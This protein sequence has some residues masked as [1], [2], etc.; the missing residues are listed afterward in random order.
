MSPAQFRTQC[1][2][3]WESLI[4]GSHVPEVRCVESSSEFSAQR[5]GQDRKKSSA[6]L[7]A[8]RSTLLK[9]H[10]VPA[11]FPTGLDLDRVDGPEN[12]L[13]S[14]LDEF[15]QAMDVWISISGV[16]RYIE[17]LDTW[18]RLQPSSDQR[19]RRKIEREVSDDFAPVRSHSSAVIGDDR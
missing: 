2:A 1:V 19:S 14:V 8:R 10:D 18:P 16:S 15:A 6:V 9:L 7:G 5:F 17:S 12:F 3:N 11:D 13:T 4:E